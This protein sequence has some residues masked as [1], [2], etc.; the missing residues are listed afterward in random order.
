MH[1]HT[2]TW[3]GLTATMAGAALLITPTAATSA[4]PVGDARTVVDVEFLGEVVV[5]TG[6]IF[7]GTEIGG[8]SSITYDA[9]AASTTRSPTIRA[10]GRPAIRSGTTPSPST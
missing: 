6:T 4:P 8:L 5:P 9:A 10:T 3:I 1:R 7:D 2:R